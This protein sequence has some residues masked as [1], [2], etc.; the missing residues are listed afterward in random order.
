MKLNKK[1]FVKMSQGIVNLYEG[2]YGKKKKIFPNIGQFHFVNKDNLKYDTEGFIYKDLKN[3]ILYIFI[4]G[5]DKFADWI[6]N[7]HFSKKVIPYKNINP[8]IKVHSG[9]LDGYILVRDYFLNLYKKFD[10]VIISGHSRGAPI[11]CLA[12]LDMQYHD[13]SKRYIVIGEGCPRWASKAMMKSYQKRIPETYIFRKGLDLISFIPFWFI[14][15]YYYFKKISKIRK[16]CRPWW[17]VSDHHPKE[18]LKAMKELPKD[19]F[20]DI[21]NKL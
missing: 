3:K 17:N 21:Y 18:Y 10:T 12:A 13:S 1:F 6:S 11:A 15:G 19:F 14:F 9:F 4:K 8:K 16:P 7:F 5:T 20:I 2:Q